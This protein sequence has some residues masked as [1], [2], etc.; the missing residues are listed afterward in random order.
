MIMCSS[1]QDGQS[2]LILAFQNG[3]IEVVDMLISAGAKVGLLN[4]VRTTKP[5]RGP[6]VTCA[7]MYC[8]R[9]YRYVHTIVMEI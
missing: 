3:H 5:F 1:L 9:L 2:W 7:H 8:C 4:K 6:M